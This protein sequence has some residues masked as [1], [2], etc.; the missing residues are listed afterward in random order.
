LQIILKQILY[1]SEFIKQRI[2]YSLVLL[3]KL[4][5]TMIFYLPNLTIFFLI[6]ILCGERERYQG[7]TIFKNL[8]FLFK[9]ILYIF[10][11]IVYV[12]WIVLMY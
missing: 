6:L 10:G 1:Y 9:I 11:I 4:E 12:F 5:K 8:N 3:L 2:F 7:R